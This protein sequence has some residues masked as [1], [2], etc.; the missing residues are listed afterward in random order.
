MV[1]PVESPGLDIR[2][3]SV[4]VRLL[5]PMRISRQ[6]AALPL[7]ASR[8]ARALFAFL[9]VSPAPVSRGHLCE[10]LWDV[11]NDPRGELRWC[12]SKLRR[13]LDEPGR[14][15][16]ETGNDTVRL[17]LTDCFVDAL[18][19]T[20]TV[21]DGIESLD[22]ERLRAISDLIGGEFLEGLELYRSPDFNAWIIAERR[23]FHGRH[24]AVLEQRWRRRGGFGEV[25]DHGAHGVLIGA[26]LEPAGLADGGADGLVETVEIFDWVGSR[27]GRIGCRSP[28][29]AC[30]GVDPTPAP[31]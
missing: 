9:A 10:L 3:S 25:G 16:V 6:G 2:N 13:V 31:S 24:L 7:P 22:A 4:R 11:P 8:K 28:C 29:G 12:L 27:R 23:R 17:D 20:R 18:A 14:R 21:R 26:V 5:G 1:T 15:R 30:P 19:V